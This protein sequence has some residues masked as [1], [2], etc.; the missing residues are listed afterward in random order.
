MILELLS[1]PLVG[2]FF[3]LLVPDKFAD[4]LNLRVVMRFIAVLT[5]GFTFVF[6]LLLLNDINTGSKNSPILALLGDTD[7]LFWSPNLFKPIYFIMD[8]ISIIF[9]VLTT[10][11]TFLVIF[12]ICFNPGVQNHRF[13]QGYLIAFLFIEFLLMGAFTVADIL[14]FY[15]FFETI[16]IPMYFI[17]GI[18]GSGYRKIKAGYY[19]FLYT[20]LGSLFML[21]G[22]IVLFMELGTTAYLPMFNIPPISLEV[23]HMVFVCFFL[24]FSVKINFYFK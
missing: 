20:L 3:I 12:S 1:I 8:G 5:A 2:I 19:F 7:Y 17:I 15:V 21:F 18:Y 9:V 14:F 16:L 4:D 10:L 22:I 23:Q 13:F 6:S 24:A 11:V